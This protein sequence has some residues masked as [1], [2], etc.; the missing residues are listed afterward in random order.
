MFRLLFSIFLSVVVARW[1]YSEVKMMWPGAVPLI[2]YVLQKVE[3]PTHDQWASSMLGRFLIDAAEKQGVS[4]DKL[5]TIPVSAHGKGPQHGIPLN[6]AQLGEL[7]QVADTVG[8]KFE[9][10]KKI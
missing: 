1:S 5:I 9:Q 2:D 3:I 8:C 10:L 7:K 6:S 4:L